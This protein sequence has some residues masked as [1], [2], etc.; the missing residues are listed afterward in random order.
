MPGLAAKLY[1]DLKEP[2]VA[3]KDTLAKFK[4]SYKGDPYLLDLYGDELMNMDAN[5]PAVSNPASA[6]HP[7]VN[8]ASSSSPNAAVSG[9]SNS[10]KEQ[11]EGSAPS[12]AAAA[13]PLGMPG[14][15]GVA[16][17]GAAPRNT[18]ALEQQ[19]QNRRHMVEAAQVDAS[20]GDM[21]EHWNVG[22]G[23]DN[24]WRFNGPYD[25]PAQDTN[26]KYLALQNVFSRTG[27]EA[28]KKGSKRLSI[29]MRTHNK[30]GLPATRPSY[31][32]YNH[33]RKSWKALNG[34]EKK[35]WMNKRSKNIRSGREQEEHIADMKNLKL[36]QLLEQKGNTQR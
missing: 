5:S 14:P 32:T 8:G 18:G 15:G 20:G 19:V 13:P 12:A 7:L 30:K 27:A 10:M 29:W 9:G 11:M 31:Y 16:A 1:K 23:A 2:G 17:A 3:I 24:G 36:A 22:K 35:R 21:Q 33:D 34:I 25:Y 4:N 28:A 6:Q 26:P